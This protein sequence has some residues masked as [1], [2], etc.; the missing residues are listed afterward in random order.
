MRQLPLG[1]G[2]ICLLVGLCACGSPAPATVTPVPRVADL[3]L[4]AQVSRL[5]FSL[6]DLKKVNNLASN[7]ALGEVVIGAYRTTMSPA[8]LLQFYQDA[9]KKAGWVADE[10]HNQAGLL[11]F[12]QDARTVSIIAVGIPSTQAVD[13]LSNVLP[14][15]RGKLKAGDSLLILAQG[16]QSAFQTV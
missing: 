12:N 10:A 9:L 8:E 1:L 6:D 14:V 11:Y 7:S 16:P 13:T 5:D 4:P 15:L 3:P 2:F